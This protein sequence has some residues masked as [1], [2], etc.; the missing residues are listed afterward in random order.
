ML[1]FCTI[2][3]HRIPISLNFYVFY[4]FIKFN[5]VCVCVCVCVTAIRLSAFCIFFSFSKPLYQWGLFVKQTGGSYVFLRRKNPPSVLR[6]ATSLVKGGFFCILFL[7]CFYFSIRSY[8]CP[9]H[10]YY[11]FVTIIL[12]KNTTSNFIY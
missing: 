10:L 6:T 2:K 3:A 11:I 9:L 7:Y 12:Q 4:F 1:L 5:R 8:K